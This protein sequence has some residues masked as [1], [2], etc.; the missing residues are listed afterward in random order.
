MCGAIKRFTISAFLVIGLTGCRS[1]QT[2]LDALQKKY[3]QLANQFKHDC[4]AEYLNVPP[5]I[6][7]KCAEEDKKVKDAWDQLQA[8]RAKQ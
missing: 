4:S 8:E 2:D 7:P 5:K 6:S 3:D 1:R